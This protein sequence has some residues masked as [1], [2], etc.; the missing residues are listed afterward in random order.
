[1]RVRL[2]ALLLFVC[3]CTS[4]KTEVSFRDPSQIALVYVSRRG[5][6]SRLLD[7]GV[8]G[9]EL[10]WRDERG[11][12]HFEMHA[13]YAWRDGELT[14]HDAPILDARDVR[15]PARVYDRAWCR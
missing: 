8:R 11:A 2:A 9:R 6:R 10:A 5:T 15:L 4:E 3:G 1:M 7:V 14:I 13:D 12:P